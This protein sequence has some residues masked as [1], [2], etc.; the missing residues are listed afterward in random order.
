MQ[1]R[2]NKSKRVHALQGGGARLARA[3]T[4]AWAGWRGEREPALRR[5][6]RG[7]AVCLGQA[8]R[9]AGRESESKHSGAGGHANAGGASEFG[10]RAVIVGVQ[11]G[12]WMGRG[13]G[14]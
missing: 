2:A 7:R 8:G 5:S 13:G 11:A 6:W 1:T 9:R 3:S 4:E 14:A 12:E 10:G